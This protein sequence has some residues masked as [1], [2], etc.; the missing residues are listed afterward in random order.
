MNNDELLDRLAKA[1]H[2]IAKQQR[3]GYGT[4]VIISP[5]IAK[6]IENYHLIEARKR[7]LNKINE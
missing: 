2:E 6:A 1:C 5:E 4:H 3:N 7:K